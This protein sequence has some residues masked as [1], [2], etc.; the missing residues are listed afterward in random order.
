MFTYVSVN[1]FF[2]L[3][4]HVFGKTYVFLILGDPG[5]QALSTASRQAGRQR[6]R[7]TSK[8]AGNQARKQANKQ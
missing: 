3:V 8:Q 5:K 4:K 2:R 1:M 6:G 7:Q